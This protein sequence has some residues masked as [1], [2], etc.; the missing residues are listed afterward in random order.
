MSEAEAM[1][2]I[3]GLCALAG[4]VIGAAIVIIGGRFR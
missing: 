1:M 2:I 4:L 3:S